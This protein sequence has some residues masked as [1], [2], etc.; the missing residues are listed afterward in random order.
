MTSTVHIIGAGVS[1]LAAAV[2][3]SNAGFA[4]HVH[5]ADAA[6]RVTG[7]KLTA[8]QRIGGILP[9]QCPD[10]IDDVGPQLQASL[11]DAGFIGVDGQG[12][13]ELERLAQHGQQA[14]QLLV[15][16]H[17]HGTRTGGFGAQIQDVGTVLEQ[18]FAM[19]QRR[20]RVGMATAVRKGIRCDIDDAHDLWPGQV[21]AKTGGLPDHASFQLGK[22][23]RGTK[24]RLL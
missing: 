20:A 16:G 4:V 7:N 9:A 2:R 18:L 6:G 15:H 5:E 21:D 8:I 1:G 12:D 10:V 24:P 19:R 3:L 23:K 14:V 11:H 17:L 13:A 22:T